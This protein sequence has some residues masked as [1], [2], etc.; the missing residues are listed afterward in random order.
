MGYRPS[1][2]ITHECPDNKKIE[3]FDKDHMHR[4]VLKPTGKWRLQQSSD[5]EIE[6]LVQ[7]RNFIFC[8]WIHEN[9]VFYVYPET[10]LLERSCS[11]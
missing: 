4:H 3:C 9:N 1:I 7:H 10:V 6:M 2:W 11:N 8:E 5:G